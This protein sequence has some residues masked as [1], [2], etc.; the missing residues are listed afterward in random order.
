MRAGTGA[1]IAEDDVVRDRIG[2]GGD[3]AGIVRHRQRADTDGARGGHLQQAATCA[4]RADD[5]S[6]GGNRDAAGEGTLSGELQQ[7]VACLGDAAVLDYRVDDQARLPGSDIDAVDER[8]TDVNRIGRRPVQV[9]GARTDGRNRARV[10]RGRRD[11]AGQGQDA[12]RSQ[13]G[14]RAAGIAEGKSGQRIIAC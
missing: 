7:S 4:A 6:A 10:A 5:Q 3:E 13:G 11:T 12:R 2:A 9:Q 8:G 14:R 1:I